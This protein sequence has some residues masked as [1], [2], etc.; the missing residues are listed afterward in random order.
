MTSTCLV[1]SKITLALDRC[2]CWHGTF[3]Y[4]YNTTC[5]SFPC[6]PPSFL[7]FLPLF[8]LSFLPL[9]FL[10]P[11][12]L[13][14]PSILPLLSSPVQI[15][16]VLLSSDHIS[17]EELHEIRLSRVPAPEASL[18]E[19]ADSTNSQNRCCL[20]HYTVANLVTYDVIFSNA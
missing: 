5:A 20:I 1:R 9:F 18:C 16:T 19:P 8:F 15:L 2:I 4:T 12:S 6:L 14:P 3:M 11:S 17:L 13:L 7:S 10:P